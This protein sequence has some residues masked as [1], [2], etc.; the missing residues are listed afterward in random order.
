MPSHYHSLV[1]PSRAPAQP[2][3]LPGEDGGRMI[4]VGVGKSGCEEK[5]ENGT[6]GMCK[7]VMGRGGERRRDAQPSTRSRSKLIT[8]H[9]STFFNT[10][11]G[12]GRR[13]AGQGPPPDASIRKALAG[14]DMNIDKH[15]RQAHDDEGNDGDHN[16]RSTVPASE[17]LPERSSAALPRKR[18]LCTK[19]LARN[20]RREAHNLPSTSLGVDGQALSES[21]AR[22]LGAE[23]HQ[24]PAFLT[25]SESSSSIHSGL[26]ETR[27][28]SFSPTLLI[29]RH[30]LST[31]LR[32]P[33]NALFAGFMLQL[34]LNSARTSGRCSGILPLKDGA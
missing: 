23:P 4:W 6:V 20:E 21:T 18:A 9:P 3:E 28:F 5:G 7:E 24:R 1:H 29:A 19:R 33:A 11:A 12:G 27:G 10:G 22:G 14:V 17:S 2:H 32:H 15:E 26:E 30:T 13:K 25:L 31:S 16:R 8:R 34:E